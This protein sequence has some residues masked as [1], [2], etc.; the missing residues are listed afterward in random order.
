MQFLYIYAGF[1]DVCA[2]CLLSFPT[3][4]ISSV[5]W[6]QKPKKKP[7]LFSEPSATPCLQ[8]APLREQ[9]LDR[10]QLKVRQ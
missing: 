1:E 10:P 8:P 7:Y 3:F 5:T 9:A 4:F 2:F 6:K